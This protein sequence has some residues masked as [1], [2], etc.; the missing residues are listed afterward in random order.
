MKLK[1]KLIM[2]AAAL[3]AC[4]ATLTST[5][6]AWYTSNTEVSASGLQ[7]G[8]ANSGDSSILISKTG[9]SGTWLQDITDLA[10]TGNP[11]LKPLMLN[12]DDGKFYTVASSVGTDGKIGLSTTPE[13]GTSSFV[14]FS[15][16]FKTSATD[17][18]VPIYLKSMSISNADT[19]LDSWENL[20]NGKEGDIGINNDAQTYQK[21]IV[22][23]LAFTITTVDSETTYKTG[24]GDS[25]TDQTFTKLDGKTAYKPISSWVSSLGTTGG[26][27]DAHK[28]FN[29]LD[30]TE[31]KKLSDAVTSD[32]SKEIDP[33]KMICVLNANGTTA[34]KVTFRFYLNGSD[35]DCFDACKGQ[36]FKLT[37]SFTSTTPTTVNT[38]NN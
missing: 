26:A 24:S 3:A 34:A 4:A 7:A 5:T 8:S 25:K 1:G 28:Y 9:E 38:G 10:A 31:T 23:A 14:E 13:N 2:S 17:E 36:K 20:N 6:Y 27:N 12:T 21:D 16:F 18:N 15:L 29:A 33:N 35:V 19:A 22:D 32:N 37:L 11:T 30:K